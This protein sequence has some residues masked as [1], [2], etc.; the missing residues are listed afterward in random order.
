MWAVLAIYLNEMRTQVDVIV[1]RFGAKE[2]NFANITVTLDR[3]AHSLFLLFFALVDF[4]SKYNRPP[5]RQMVC[6]RGFAVRGRHRARY[7]SFAKDELQTTARGRLSSRSITLTVTFSTLL[8][9]S[10]AVGTRTRGAKRTSALI[11]SFTI[12]NK[13]ELKNM[14][15][16]LSDTNLELMFV[17]TT[18]AWAENRLNCKRNGVFQRLSLLTGKWTRGIPKKMV[19]SKENRNATM[20]AR[21]TGSAEN[22]HKNQQNEKKRKN[23][24][25]NKSTNEISLAKYTTT[26]ARPTAQIAPQMSKR[27]TNRKKTNDGPEEIRAIPVRTQTTTIPMRRMTNEIEEWQ[28]DQAQNEVHKI[29]RLMVEWSCSTSKLYLAF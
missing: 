1:E 7:S 16:R 4:I 6:T 11:A 28:N 27:E 29:L 15:N 21:T 19:Q 25:H 23:Q 12:P 9:V 18:R 2:S 14:Y 20:T 13:Q 17:W 5:F 26:T 10:T 22:L 24:N 8:M 3:R